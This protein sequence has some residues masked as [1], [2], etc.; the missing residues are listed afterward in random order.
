MFLNDFSAN[1]E[2][3]QIQI[4]RMPRTQGSIENKRRSTQFIVKENWDMAI[5]YIYV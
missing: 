5:I 2:R 3:N 4:D 1:V